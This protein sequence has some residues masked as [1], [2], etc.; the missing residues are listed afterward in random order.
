MSKFQVQLFIKVKKS[1]NAQVVA[2][3][4]MDAIHQAQERCPN[5][6]RYLEVK[7]EGHRNNN[8]GFNREMRSFLNR[9]LLTVA[10]HY[11]KGMRTPTYRYHNPLD[12][13][14]SFPNEPYTAKAVA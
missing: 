13:N 5:Q 2:A 6:D 12:Q 7:I 8:G 3:K 10:A 9:F 1:D 14:N 4:V 11:V